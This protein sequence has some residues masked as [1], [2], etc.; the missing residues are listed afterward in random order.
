MT[1][2]SNASNGYS[3]NYSGNTL[4]S[5]S[6]QLTAMESSGAS[7]PN[8]KQFGM[9]LVSNTTPAVGSNVSGVGVGAATAGY[10]SS[11]QFKFK[12]G[13]EVIATA[14][15]PTNSNV[16]TTSYIANMDG[17]TAAGAYST[18][19]TYGITANF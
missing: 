7:T 17:S 4:S 1:V 19:L 12:P 9:N 14:N 16:F 8:S 18:A 6:N 10:N 15:G 3:I 5:G 11:N 2:A 13:G